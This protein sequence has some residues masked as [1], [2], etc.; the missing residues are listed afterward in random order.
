MA[1]DRTPAKSDRERR[2]RYLASQRRYNES[3][4]GKKRERHY[5][6][7]VARVK[8]APVSVEDDSL[9]RLA[10]MLK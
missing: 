8:G 1:A 5:K 2:E 4:K 10:E 9:V 6:D 7:A 3:R